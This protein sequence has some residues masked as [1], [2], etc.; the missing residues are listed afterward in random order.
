MDE[1]IDKTEKNEKNK[2]KC[3]KISLFL[4]IDFQMRVYYSVPLCIQD[5]NNKLAKEFMNN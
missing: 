3:S 5:Y 2:S 4:G 1:V